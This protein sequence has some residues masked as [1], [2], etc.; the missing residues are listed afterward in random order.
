[1]KKK[2]AVTRPLNNPPWKKYWVLT[3]MP[4][5][6]SLLLF[7]LLNPNWIYSYMLICWFVFLQSRVKVGKII[8]LVLSV[9]SLILVDS[10]HQFQ[11]M[12]T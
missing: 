5:Y 7:T 4:Q 10:P 6:Y 1:L 9:L 3:K 11:R 8:F 2:S 12:G